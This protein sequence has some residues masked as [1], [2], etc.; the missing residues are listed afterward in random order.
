[1]RRLFLA[2][3]LFLVLSAQAQP[4]FDDGLMAYSRGD[5][6]GA[7]EIWRPLAKQGHAAAQYSLGLL[8]QRGEGVVASSKTAAK[9]YRLAANHGD[10]DAQLN[11]G[12][13]YANGDGVTRDYERAY[14]WFSLAYMT[15]PTGEYQNAAFRNR[16][17]VASVMTQEQID[18]AEGLVR[19][20]KP[21]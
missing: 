13:L 15:Y 5:S 3:S 11:L 18:H 8:Y 20:W 16:E 12:L 2:V 4:S 14:M 1:M 10:P 9:W 17:N 7:M 21:K 6:E 19:K